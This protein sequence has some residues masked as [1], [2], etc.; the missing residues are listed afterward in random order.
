MKLQDAQ[1]LCGPTALSNALASLG[2]EIPPAACATLCHATIEGAD[3][4]DIERAVKELGFTPERITTWLALCGALVAGAPVVCS[5]KETEPY[6]HWVAVIG[7]LGD[8]LIVVDSLNYELV[9]AYKRADWL[10]IW[11]GPEGYDGIALL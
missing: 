8:R 7:V 4:D 6:D 1:H 2:R 5:V 11:H 3:E 9:V 10:E